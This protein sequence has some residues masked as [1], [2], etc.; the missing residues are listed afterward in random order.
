MVNIETDIVK[1][2]T[3]NKNIDLERY[4]DLIV[5]SAVPWI[6]SEMYGSVCLNCELFNYES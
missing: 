6:S 1:F 4:V 5:T 3:Y 2:Y